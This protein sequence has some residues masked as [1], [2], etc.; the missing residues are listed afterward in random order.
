MPDVLQHIF[1]VWLVFKEVELYK[2]I[3]WTVWI[4]VIAFGKALNHLIA[5]LIRIVV[6][7]K[8]T[9]Y[10]TGFHRSLSSVFCRC[11]LLRRSLNSFCLFHKFLLML[12]SGE[13]DGCCLRLAGQRIF[14]PVLF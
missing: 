10:Y 6:S 3:E 11:A 4:N 9:G 1:R 13:S 14:F 5:Y 7:I 2:G 8:C 12:D